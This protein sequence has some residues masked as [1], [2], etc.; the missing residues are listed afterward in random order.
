MSAKGHRANPW[1]QLPED[2]TVKHTRRGITRSPEPISSATAAPGGIRE[3]LWFVD[4]LRVIELHDPHRIRQSS[5]VRSC[6]FRDPEIAVPENALDLE[7]GGLAG[8][9]TLQGLQIPS[10]KNP[11]ASLLWNFKSP[12]AA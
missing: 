3:I 11:L 7:A 10:P 9:M 6:L 12:F 2:E 1:G 8:M 5:V 4:D